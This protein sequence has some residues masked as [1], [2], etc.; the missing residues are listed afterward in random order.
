M[1]WAIGNGESRTNINVD[2]LEG[3]KVGC[4]AIA[5]DYYVDT[6]V[7]VDRRMVQE[8]IDTN[9]P[10]VIL[11]R[12]DWIDRFSMYRNIK[13]VPK[14][15]Y[16][17]N[18]RADEPFHWGSGPYAVLEAT[19]HSNRI[20]L[21]G[22]DLYSNTD[23]VNN[24]YKDTSNYDASSKRSVDPRYWIHQIGKIFECFPTKKF[25]IYQNQDW[26]IPKAWKHTNVSLDNISNIV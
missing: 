8:A 25:V 22:F 4:N 1:T 24:I 17:G 21:L 26:K 2:L 16:K 19:K 7:C 9:F 18:E 11:T 3:Y 10:N 20:K 23:N 15:P 13:L 6:I 5:R 14:L 12:K